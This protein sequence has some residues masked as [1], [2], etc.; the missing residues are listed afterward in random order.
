LPMVPVSFRRAW[1]MS[2]AC[3]PM[4]ESPI[5]PSISARGT[6]AATRSTT[7]T[8]MAPLRTSMSAISRACS[9]VSGWETSSSS[10][11]TPSLRA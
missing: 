6:S 9:P 5:S 2:R 10:Q 1:D 3:S 8:S 11:L 7:M 4:W